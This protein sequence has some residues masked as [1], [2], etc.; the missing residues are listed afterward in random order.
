MLTLSKNFSNRLYMKKNL[1]IIDYD[2]LIYKQI[3]EDHKIGEHVFLL[4]E[5][6]LSPHMA[7]LQTSV[8]AI[9]E[10][11]LYICSVI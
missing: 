2:K 4:D 1:Q 11:I 9:R 6:Q 3:K 8:S 7:H 5:Y 10:I